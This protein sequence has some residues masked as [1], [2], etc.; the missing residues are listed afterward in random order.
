MSLRIITADERLAE[1]TG[2]V[3]SMQRQ[4]SI[5]ERSGTAFDDP[6]PF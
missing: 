2:Y 3:D 4:A 6:I 1:A 5:I